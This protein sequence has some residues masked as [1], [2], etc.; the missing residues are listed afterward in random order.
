M[1]KLLFLEIVL[2]P[3]KMNKNKELI[4]NRNL[5]KAKYAIEDFEDAINGL[6]KVSFVHGALVLA[7][8]F[9]VFMGAKNIVNIFFS[10][11]TIATL[12]GLGAKLS[13]RTMEM[14]LTGLVIYYFI[15]IFELVIGG[16]PDKLIPGLGLNHFS[17]G[18]GIVKLFNEVS[19]L[20]YLGS[21][22]LLGYPFF[23]IL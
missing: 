22:A 8:L 6:K 21:R 11:V 20:V 18:S 14:I 9:S 15:L 19:P 7:L 17:R 1:N 23:R 10:L 3:K 16:I 5:R 2:K 4:E 12:L 13:F